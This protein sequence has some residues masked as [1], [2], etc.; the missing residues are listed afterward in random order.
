MILRR[1][2]SHIEIAVADTG[3]GISLNFSH[4]FERFRLGK[5]NYESTLWRSWIQGSPL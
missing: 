5:G 2:N 1:V 3:I 4:V